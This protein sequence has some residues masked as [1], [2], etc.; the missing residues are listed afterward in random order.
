VYIPARIPVELISPTSVE[1]PLGV[2]EAVESL[3]K[4]ASISESLAVGVLE[5]LRLLPELAELEEMVPIGAVSSVPE[6]YA[7]T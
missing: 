3:A 2:K 4:P 5:T 1:P 7:M 6:T